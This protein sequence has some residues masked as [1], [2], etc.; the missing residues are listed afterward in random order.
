VLAQAAWMRSLDKQKQVMSPDQMF[1]TAIKSGLMAAND[2]N[3]I[4]PTS[5]STIQLAVQPIP[6]M[7]LAFKPLAKTTQSLDEVQAEPAAADAPATEA[8]ATEAAVSDDSSDSPVQAPAVVQADDAA[9]DSA[10]PAAAA[11]AQVPAGVVEGQEQIADNAVPEDS[12]VFPDGSQP[13]GG[14]PAGYHLVAAGVASMQDPALSKPPIFDTF[15]GSP[16]QMPEKTLGVGIV[17]NAV[18][19]PPALFPGGGWSTETINGLPPP[20]QITV[21]VHK[22]SLPAAPAAEEAKPEEAKP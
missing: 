18:N 4:V 14:I 8:G 3:Q 16:F 10:L 7:Q 6:K 13:Y 12:P 19:L 11:D 22:P 9:A 21:T 15:Q 5:P 17:E 2:A 1:M 20:A